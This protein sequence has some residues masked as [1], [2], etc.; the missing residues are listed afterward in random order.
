[1]WEMI[2]VRKGKE[3]K[4]GGGKRRGEKYLSH[5]SLPGEGLGKGGRSWR[6]AVRRKAYIW[7]TNSGGG[8]GGGG[9][10][11]C[12][13]TNL[14]MNTIQPR[15]KR[16][17]TRG[18]QSP[19][20]RQAIHGCSAGRGWVQKQTKE[21]SKEKPKGCRRAESRKKKLDGGRCDS[22]G[23]EWFG[24]KGVVVGRGGGRARVR[25]AGNSNKGTW[26]SVS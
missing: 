4:G 20:E 24:E 13:R 15:D 22:N 2:L 17:S 10:Q 19:C 1:M 14:L 7:K 9:G 26:G 5:R 21:G 23:V 6:F 25:G 8:G 12:A 11:T 18:K 3:K 16:H